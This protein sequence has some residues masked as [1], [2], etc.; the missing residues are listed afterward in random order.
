[1]P[2]W[3]RSKPD[4]LANCCPGLAWVT[5]STLSAGAVLVSAAVVCLSDVTAPIASLI[6]IEM[7]EGASAA[8][9]RW[10]VVAVAWIIAIVD[11]AVEAGTA[12]VPGT[13]SDEQPAVE[14]VRPIVAIGR[15]VIRRIVV[16]AIGAYRR[17]SD[18]DRY[19]GWCSGSSGKKHGA[20]CRKNKS[21]HS[22]RVTPL[23]EN[24]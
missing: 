4:K 11:M 17:D 6:P 13:S 22:N 12:V 18:A 14:P 1:M 24:C 9:R 7:I 23:P 5:A 2:Y 8:L 10:A 19:L 15:A 3:L 16:I 21:L 20:H